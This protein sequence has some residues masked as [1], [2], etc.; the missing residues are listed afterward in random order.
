ML[1]RILPAAAIATAASLVVSPAA[2]HHPLA[3]TPMT[4]FEPGV[5]S[6]I[7]HPLLGFDH[8]FF[9]IAVGIAAVC[10]R[11]RPMAP[12]AY[13]TAMLT[14]VAPP[15]VE[16]M[17]ALSLLVV[18]AI[19]MSGRAL[20]MPAAGAL[21]A[22]LGL[23]HGWAFGG[24]IAGQEAA[25]PAGAVAGYPLGP[26]AV[27][28]LIAMAAGYT[29]SAELQARLASDTGARLGGAMVAGI[30]AFLVLE[31]AEGATSSALGIG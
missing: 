27:Q 6:G 26:A 8:L 11:R 15:M 16:P 29:V 25:A 22:I 12:L 3:G 2:A 14:G 19:V 18:G 21:F 31:V 30:G 5:L 13:V 17:I 24:P 20:S 4:R 23:F 7:G 1:D 10:T 28:W 9:V